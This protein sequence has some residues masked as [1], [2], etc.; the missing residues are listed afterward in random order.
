MKRT[1]I[2]VVM[3]A[4]MGSRML[5]ITENIPKPLISI[6]NTTLIETVIDGLRQRE[7]EKIYVVVGYLKEQFIRLCAKYP[8][9]ELIENT[10]YETKNNISSVYA[11]R[12][13]I[14]G[15]NCFICEADLYIN[16]PT[17]FRKEF[18][19]SG[20]LARFCQEY[21]DDWV[22]EV[23][24]KFR[25]NRIFVGGSK[26][27]NMAGISYFTKEDSGILAAAIEQAYE[28][29]G[30]DNLFWDE[31]VDQQLE[32]LNLTVYPID[33]NAIIEVDTIQELNEV[34]QQK[35]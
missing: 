18:E 10:D 32:K 5:P 6:Q 1:E 13:V 17:V 12:E 3:A 14:R 33:K 16:D 26:K 35:L 9:V 11:A 29:E 25:I 24:D 28:A 20:Y 34:R 2:A 4:G 15:S 19:Q 23:D 30:N 31:V 8:E 7:P 27:Y 21:S 22:F